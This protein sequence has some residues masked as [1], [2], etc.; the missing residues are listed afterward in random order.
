MANSGLLTIQHKDIPIPTGMLVTLLKIAKHLKYSVI[1]EGDNDKIFVFCFLNTS[2]GKG[3]N[4]V[5]PLMDYLQGLQRQT[6]VNTV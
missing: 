4:D 3:C 1:S 6:E 2:K 5:S